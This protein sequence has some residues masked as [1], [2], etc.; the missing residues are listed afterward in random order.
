MSRAQPVPFRRNA[1]DARKHEGQDDATGCGKKDADPAPA[2][3]PP[4]EK[5][6]AGP[7]ANPAGQP[8]PPADPGANAA[9]AAP[10]E[11]TRV[12]V[13]WSPK[14]V[15]AQENPVLIGSPVTPHLVGHVQFFSGAEQVEAAGKMMVELQ[16]RRVVAGLPG[17]EGR[18]ADS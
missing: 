1:V 18:H 13:R 4:A 2:A 9:P 16:D 7:K 5:G 17:H 10:G 6:G 11:P 15:Y 8:A 12:T 14:V 3:S